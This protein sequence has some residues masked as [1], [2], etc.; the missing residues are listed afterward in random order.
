M[1]VSGNLVEILIILLIVIL[2]G[3]VVGTPVYLLRELGTGPLAKARG[4]VLDVTPLRQ[5]LTVRHEAESERLRGEAR[6]SIAELDAELGR[7]R[8]GLRASTHEQEKQLAELRERYVSLDEQATHMLEQGLRD[9]R[10]GMGTA[11]TTLATRQSNGAG[12][13]IG[14]RRADAL[15]DLYTKLAKFEATLMAV[16]NPLLLPGEPFTLPAELPQESLRWENW[17]DVGDS[18]FAFAS[19]FN[20]E[21]IYLDDASCRALA[22]FVASLRERLTTTIY[23]NL[24][25]KLSTSGQEALRTSLEQLGVDIP[26]M[27]DQLERSFRE[28][29]RD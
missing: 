2:A 25:P 28:L 13:A 24:K 20:Q 26:A 23:P 12:D 11:L 18:A 29:T 4:P 3:L 21:R 27:R 6:S 22:T 5:E 7:F 1:E 17:K 15:A 10:E 14:A 16:V 9:L 8:E 19:S